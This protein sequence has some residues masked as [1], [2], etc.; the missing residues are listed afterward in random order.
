MTWRRRDSLNTGGRRE[1]MRER[2]K[3][4]CH[5]TDG[6][7]ENRET[8]QSAADAANCP[9]IIR[10]R[11]GVGGKRKDRSRGAG[12]TTPSFSFSSDEGRRM[13]YSTLIRC[14]CDV[15]LENSP[16]STPSQ[17]PS[18]FCN[19][20]SPSPLPQLVLAFLTLF[21]FLLCFFSQFLFYEYIIYPLSCV[22]SKLQNTTISYQTEKNNSVM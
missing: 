21:L 17:V 2:G 22:S 11:A 18:P 19:P 3:T 14:N 13:K 5:P 8:I 1:R 4:A 15:V 9:L 12:C 10:T 7:P 16:G 20:L 6:G